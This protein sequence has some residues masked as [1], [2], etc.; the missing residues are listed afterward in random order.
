[1]GL[2]AG[3]KVR[4]QLAVPAGLPSQL[5]PLV[6]R[7]QLLLQS[8]LNACRRP[9]TK[10]DVRY[11]QTGHLFINNVSLWTDCGPAGRGFRFRPWQNVCICTVTLAFAG[12][13]HSWTAPVLVLAPA[14]WE[15]AT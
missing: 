11:W 9:A 13:P 12:T 8:S 3:S 5:S 15:H 4:A 14:G 2:P 6:H 10:P 1:M 7:R